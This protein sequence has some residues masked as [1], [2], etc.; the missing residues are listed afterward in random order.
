MLG[1][2]ELMAL[3]RSPIFRRRLVKTRGEAGRAFEDIE[4]RLKAIEVVEQDHVERRRRGPFLIVAAHV[5]V[6]VVDPPNPARMR[7]KPIAR[8]RAASA[9]SRRH[10]LVLVM[11][12][13]R[14][15]DPASFAL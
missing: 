5:K 8:R 9:S 15:R 7:A 11:R 14:K 4:S 6:D 3:H 2:I 10:A 13:A 12:L 1:Y